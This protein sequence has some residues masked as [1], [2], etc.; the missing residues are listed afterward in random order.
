VR[1]NP[2]SDAAA[3]IVFAAVTYAV[4]MAVSPISVRGEAVLMAASMAL[5]AGGVIFYAGRFIKDPAVLGILATA[6]LAGMV[7]RTW[8]LTESNNTDYLYCLKP[9]VEDFRENGWGAIAHTWSDY[10]MPYLYIIGGIARVPVN[11]LYL[12]KLVSII[13]DCGIAAAGVRLATH[14]NLSGLRRS[15][16]GGALFLAPTVWLNSSFWGQCDSIYAFFCLA[17]F[18]LV[19][20]DKPAFA[21]A[22]AAIAFSFKL[23]TVFIL[24]I[25]IILLMTKRV[26]WWREASVFLGTFF[27]T[28]LPAWLMGRPLPSI[29]KVYSNQTVY[30]KDRLNL[31]SPSAYALLGENLTFTVRQR[32]I[33]F[34]AG[35]IF[36]FLFLSVLLM[37]AWLNRDRIGDKTLFLFALAMVIGIPWLLPT[38][39]DR[40]FYLAD[41]FCVILA[42]MMPKRWYF[43]PFCILASY[44]GYHAF[45]FRTFIFWT[46]HQIPGLL[47]LFLAGSAV[48]L[49]LSEL[50]KAE[51]A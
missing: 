13:F 48:V 38:M 5:L 42:V 15:V 1:R 40:Y 51:P 28:V 27:L 30:Y 47:M 46:G 2:L 23:Q 8:S 3:V 17:A 31:N 29:L 24:P 37:I 26:K 19:L 21:A 33:F 41:I 36:A 9:W 20:K 10:N 7:I 39:H 12:Y 11:D 45:L 44:S 16:L 4:L 34:N 25:F 22:S 14:Y 50:R 49:L 43:A 18:I 6:L 35:L 32:E